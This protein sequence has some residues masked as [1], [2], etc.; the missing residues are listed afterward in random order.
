MEDASWLSK[1]IFYWV[2]PL[3]NKGAQGKLNNADD[4]FDLPASLDCSIVSS[5]LEKALM[6]NIDDVQKK[7]LHQRLQGNFSLLDGISDRIAL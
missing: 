5:K 7:I 1:I 4:L 6:G 3:M 2:N